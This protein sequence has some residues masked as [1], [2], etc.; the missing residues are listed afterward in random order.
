MCS[1]IVTSTVSSNSPISSLCIVDQSQQQCKLSPLTSSTSSSTSSGNSSVIVKPCSRTKSSENPSCNN[2][3]SCS[4]SSN[5]P[6][7]VVPLSKVAVADNSNSNKREDLTSLGSDDSGIICG[8]ESY[9]VSLNRIHQSHEILDSG[10]MDA[11]EE[12]IEILDTTSMN[13]EYGML[14]SNLCFYQSPD[15][16]F[17]TPKKT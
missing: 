3:N 5:K 7:I 17:Q 12:C 4:N 14:Q 6:P 15:N 16:D 10:E 2:N 8:S 11:E 13:E 1:K 9:Q